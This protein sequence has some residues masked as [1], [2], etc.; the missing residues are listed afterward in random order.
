MG[1]LTQLPAGELATLV[2]TKQVSPVEITEAA[3]YRVEQLDPKLHAFVE[4][5]AERARSRATEL[6]EQIAHG[7][8]PGPLAGVPLGV[9]DLIA[10]AGVPTR[11]G[12]PAYRDF[13]PE[14][15]DV[16]VE[17]AIRELGGTLNDVIRT[18]VYLA[19]GADWQDAARAHGERFADVRPANTT[20]HVAALVGD[21]FLVEV[22]A[23]AVVA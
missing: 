17:R 12:S 1:D 19:P 3:L 11:S 6:A 22:E 10:T 4:L 23:L 5:T 13:V 18:A 9:K 20:L 14:E 2:R 8:D 7:G 21:D 15:D 16:C